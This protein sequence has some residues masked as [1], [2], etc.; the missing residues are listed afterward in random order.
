MGASRNHMPIQENSTY[1][2]FVALIICIHEWICQTY[3]ARRPYIEAARIIINYLFFIM[4]IMVIM[5]L[6]KFYVTSLAE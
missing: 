6:K 4:V 1:M 3:H 2:T 5:N